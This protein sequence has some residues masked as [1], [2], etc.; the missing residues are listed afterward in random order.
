MGDWQ[1]KPKPPVRHDGRGF[2]LDFEVLHKEHLEKLVEVRFVTRAWQTFASVLKT[3]DLDL[4][5]LEPIMTKWG[6][7]KI[8]KC[9][10][11]GHQLPESFTLQ[12]EPSEDPTFYRLSQ[13]DAQLMLRGWGLI[14]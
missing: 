13:L 9:L 8:E 14:D 5:P 10:G 6:G 11:A 3:S 4:T 2:V 12:M 7:E 1:I